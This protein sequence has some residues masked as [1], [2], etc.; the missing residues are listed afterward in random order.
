MNWLKQSEDV[1]K[2]W[3]DAQQ[4]IW[5][6]WMSLMQTPS[7]SVPAMWGK[8]LDAWQKS[9]DEALS[10]QDKS[11]QLWMAQAKDVE[12]TPEQL[13]AWL[14]QGEEM[15][16][17]WQATQKQLWGTWFDLIRKADINMTAMPMQAQAQKAFQTWQ[18]SA[19]KMM[20]AQSAWV[21]NWTKSK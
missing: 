3:T 4:N 19:D 20:N 18:E 21:K 14:T 1:V 17:Q 7:M 16:A 11:F 10:A 12:N 2:T 5:Q 6:S 9:V 13:Q 8:M 15:T